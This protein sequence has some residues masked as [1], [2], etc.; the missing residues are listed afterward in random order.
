MVIKRPAPTESVWVPPAWD[1]LGEPRGQVRV[2]VITPSLT[3]GG[4]ERHIL[5]LLKSTR[6]ELRWVGVAVTQ[7]EHLRRDVAVEAE[8]VCPV[9]IGWGA[10]V[11]LAR[12]CDVVVTWGIP[13]WWER[14]PDPLPCPVVMV[15]HGSGEWTRRVTEGSERAAALV[16]VSRVALE[17]FSPAERRRAVV[18]PNGVE[19]ERVKVTVPRAETRRRWG[20]SETAKLIGYLGRFSSEKDCGAL[21]RAVA[22]LPDGWCGAFIGRA[23]GNEEVELREA[24]AR[25]CPGRMVFPGVT[26]DV[27]SALRALDWLLLASDQEGFGLVIAEAWL[28][29]V[30]VVCTPVGI[31]L[32][33][34]ELVR[35]VSIGASGAEL[36]ETFLSDAADA[37]RLRRRVERARRRAAR[38]YGAERSG[39]EWARLIRSVTGAL[40]RMPAW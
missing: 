35:T 27:G 8:R 3:V 5:T 17:P 7:P 39:R 28:A 38:R 13:G 11:E 2:G 14:L 18:I 40:T 15:S 36:A 26:D 4:A 23:S 12:R 30:P 21:V 10:A 9:G 24:V 6:R 31:A 19:P 29:G 16:A 1:F 20:V 33:E 32:E 22:T 37:R 25:E 34:P